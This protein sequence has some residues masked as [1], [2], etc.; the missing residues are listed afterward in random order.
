MAA[1]VRPHLLVLL[2]AGGPRLSLLPGHTSSAQ[3]MEELSTDRAMAPL[4]AAEA[5]AKVKG[6]LRPTSSSDSDHINIL[7][8]H[9]ERRDAA[10]FKR[11]LELLETLAGVRRGAATSVPCRTGP[12]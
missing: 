3:D 11:A 9:R 12:R 1:V 6:P 2:A 4:F 10:D 5:E 7:Q 8:G